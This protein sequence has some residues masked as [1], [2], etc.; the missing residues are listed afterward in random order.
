MIDQTIDDPSVTTLPIGQTGEL[1]VR[2]V[3]Q[4]RENMERHADNVRRE[5]LIKIEMARDDPK[6]AAEKR[7]PDRRHSEFGKK[8]RELK[9]KFAIDVEIENALGLANLVGGFEGRRWRELRSHQEP[10][11]SA[12]SDILQRKR[13]AAAFIFESACSASSRMLSASSRSARV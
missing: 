4:V 2:V 6:N 1:S 3:E 9:T 8:S 5:V 12:N 11:L 13:K 10:I 7:D